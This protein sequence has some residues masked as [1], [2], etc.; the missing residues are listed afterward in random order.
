MK[1]LKNKKVLLILGI[2]LAILIVIAT[3]LIHT[4][5]KY[6][7]N[8]ID[9]VD[10]PSI[11]EIEKGNKSDLDEPPET[12]QQVTDSIYKEEQKEDE[13]INILLCGMDARK[14]D[15]NSRSDT[16]IL[17]SYNKT[18]H[19][20]KLVSFMRDTWVYIPERGWNR[21]NAATAYGGTGL[22]VNTLNYNFGLDIQNYI[23]IKFD[24][25]KRVI[26]I[27]G[28]IDIELTKQEIN[29][30]NKKLHNEDKDWK[31]D[32]EA[33]PGIVHLNGTQALWHCRNR[34]IG[35]SDFDRTER[36]RNVLNTIINKIM[37]MDIA[38]ATSLIY[39][40]KDYV[41]MNVPLSTVIELG[42]DAIINGSLSIESERIPYD[43]MFNYANKNGASVIEIDL[44][45]T[46]KKLHEFIGYEKLIDDVENN[47][48]DK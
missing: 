48:I 29:Y 15:T 19:T 21:I 10:K 6:Y 32:I 30:I 2:L 45:Q 9:I 37:T 20:V 35:N 44:E 3:F 25:F 12:T 17:A 41:N 4:I 31:N 16:I 42:S 27:L 26:D 28:G 8:Q 14:Y 33:E 5:Y 39:E 24:D 40:M 34:S 38:T 7:L 36:Q 23:Q 11:E 18:N 43:D 22:L 1:I 47:K 46:T 13:I